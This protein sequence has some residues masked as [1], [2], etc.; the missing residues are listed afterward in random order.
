MTG[1]RHRALRGR[2]VTSITRR[3]RLRQ[4]RLQLSWGLAQAHVQAGNGARRARSGLDEIAELVDQ[5]KSLTAE[6]QFGPSPVPGQ[7]IGDLPAVSDL[8]DDLEPPVP[9][10]HRSIAAGVAHGIG[11]ELADG[12][13][14]VRDTRRRETG[15]LGAARDKAAAR[16]QVVPVAQR[17]GVRGRPGQRPLAPRRKARRTQVAASRW[18]VAT[19]GCVLAASATT[20]RGSRALS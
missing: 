4:R 12:D 2:P 1:W 6:H 17:L 20:H 13:D 18:A 15:L 5:P 19:D 14:Q 8:A 10:L 3:R 7:R 16:S 11:G 9:D